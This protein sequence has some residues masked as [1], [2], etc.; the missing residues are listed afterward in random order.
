MTTATTLMTSEEFMALPDDGI[1]RDLIRGE[2]RERGMT[3]R[4][5][6]HSSAEPTIAHRLLQWLETQPEPRGKVFSG[7]GGFRIER[8]PDTTIGIDVAFASAAT[9]KATP[10]ESKFIEGAPVLAVEILSPSDSQEDVLE[11]VQLYLAAGVKL[12]WVVEPVFRTVLVYRPDAEPEMFN[13]TQEIN[14]EPHL[15]GFRVRVEKLFE[16]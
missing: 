6:N 1:E 7:E 8:D 4:N 9:V 15:P 16:L 12:I 2:L 5:K 14:A 3:R 10:P 11:K 13:S